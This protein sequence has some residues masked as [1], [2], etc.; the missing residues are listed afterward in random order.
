MN[1]PLRRRQ[2]IELGIAWFATSAALRAGSP[3]RHPPLPGIVGINTACFS[4]QQRAA[5]AT[6]RVDPYDLPRLI[7]EELDLRILDVVSTMLDTREHA[8]LEKFRAAAERAGCVITNLKVNVPDLRFDSEDANTR[9][10]SLDEYKRWIDAAAVLGARWLRPF[11]ARTAPRWQTLVASF[12]ELADHAATRGIT[13]LIENYQWLDKEPDAI[14][15]LVAALSGRVAAQ[16]DTFNWVD[17]ATRREGLA[18]AFPHAAS[19]DFKVRDLGPNYEHPAY[20]LRPCFELGRQAGFRGP[21]CIEHLNAD[22]ASLLRELRWI[23]RQLHTW[24][25]EPGR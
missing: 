22:K 6:Q 3:T 14:P 7:R 16:P 1:L 25:A 20:D 5:D 24:T 8:P 9:R 10:H 4:R 13:L 21:W 17:D 2:F 19:C 12:A 11:P 15:R 18:K 23:T